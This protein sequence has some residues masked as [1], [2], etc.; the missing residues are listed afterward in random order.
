MLLLYT[1]DYSERF[2]NLY[3]EGFLELY[4]VIQLKLQRGPVVAF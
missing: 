2:M 1:S 4:C 3:R